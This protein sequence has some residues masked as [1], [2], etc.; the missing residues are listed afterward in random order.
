M[1]SQPRIPDERFR[2]LRLKVAQLRLER[3]L[4]LDALA[5]EAGMSRR[6]LTALINGEER[7]GVPMQGTLAVWYRIAEALDV[8]LSELV[9]PLD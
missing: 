1:P 5:A 8:P 2:A 6:N 4:T 7:N 9:K 3:D